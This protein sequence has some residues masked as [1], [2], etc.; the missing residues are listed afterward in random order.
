MAAKFLFLASSG[1]FKKTAQIKQ[2]SKRQKFG[3]SGHLASH[4]N[5]VPILDI[6]KSRLEKFER[7][8][9]FIA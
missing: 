5:L 2:L 9:G 3:Q 7:L 8:A 6:L 1:I 4:A